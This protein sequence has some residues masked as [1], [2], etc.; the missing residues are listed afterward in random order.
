MRKELKVL[1]AKVRD[2]IAE[3]ET[4]VYEEPVKHTLVVP[5]QPEKGDKVTVGQTP[6]GR[7]IV[8]VV[9]APKVRCDILAYAGLHC[10][11]QMHLVRV[12]PHGG[13]EGKI[14]GNEFQSLFLAGPH[15]TRVTLATGTGDDWEA[16]TWRTIKLVP[17]KTFT[18]KNGK[19]AVRVPDLD[20]LERPDA[21][22]ADPNASVNYPHAETRDKGEGWTFGRPGHLKNRVRVIYVDKE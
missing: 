19:Q 18:A 11:G 9:V 17:G 3:A 7:Y 15:G 16:Y 5:P 12:L 2:A 6:M 13:F 14:D 4:P 1:A 21:F 8:Q 22:R 20:T 10:G